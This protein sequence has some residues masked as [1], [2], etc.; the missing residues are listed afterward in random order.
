[1]KRRPNPRAAADAAWNAKQKPCHDAPGAD[2]SPGWWA[3]PDLDLLSDD[4]PPVPEFSWDAIPPSWHEYLK[5]TSVDCSAP[6]DYVTTNL[7]G[8]GSAILGNVR[9]ASPWP[10]WVEQPHLWMANV[11]PPSVGKTPSLV[12][13]KNVMSGIED[14]DHLDYQRVLQKWERDMEAADAKLGAWKQDVKSAARKNK[15]PP[16][17]PETPEKPTLNRVLIVDSTT[18][19]T[20]HILARNPRGLAMIRGELSGW[21]GQLDRYGGAGADRAFYLE[22]WDGGS[23]THDRVKYNGVPVRVPY[24]SLAIIGGLQPDKLRELFAG[25]DDGLTSRFLYIYPDP[26][27]PRRPTGGAN[28][29]FLRDA[30]SRLKRL[31]WDRN[32]LGHNIPKVIGIDERGLAVLDE[33]RTQLYSHRDGP[34]ILTN[35]RGKNP[36]RLIRLALTFEFLEWAATG[37]SEPPPI[38]SERS[39]LRAATYLSYAQMMFIRTIGELT[40]DET[41]KL[42]TAIARSLINERLSEFKERDLYQRPGFHPLRNSE[43]RN[44]VL[45]KL[46]VAKIIRKASSSRPGRHPNLW[47]VN[48]QLLQR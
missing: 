32:G 12:P 28:Q 48:P 46:S 26:I 21:I 5:A 38:I 23:F 34:A 9:R 17:K 15:A 44:E 42:A 4:R 20:V 2:Q 6:V 36:R 35:W 24:C 10:G 7:I 41:E 43:T 39:M 31:S 47:H 3:D 27:P 16:D 29:L 22:S 45:E 37:A 25:P 8:V 19:E 14:E 11:G 30:L 13:F 1:M 18:E 40:P 33:I